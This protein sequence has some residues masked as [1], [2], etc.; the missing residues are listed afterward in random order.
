VSDVADE[1]QK[2][3]IV[4]HDSNIAVA[5]SEPCISEAPSSNVDPKIGYSGFSGYSPTSSGQT[6]SEQFKKVHNKLSSRPTSLS[7]HYPAAPR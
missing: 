5:L 2:S 4:R 3:Q 1:I 7:R 6:P